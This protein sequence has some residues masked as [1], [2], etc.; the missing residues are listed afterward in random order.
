MGVDRAIV[1]SR[2]AS[3]FTSLVNFCW[4][5][6]K[7]TLLLTFVSILAGGGYLYFRLDDEIRRQVQLRFANHY[8]NFD[9]HIGSA[10]FDPDRGIAIDDLSLT[11]KTAD[12]TAAEPLLSIDEMYLVGNLRIE[13]LVTNQMQIDEV[14]VRHAHMRIERQSDG[15]WNTTALLPLPHFSEQSPKITIEDASATIAYSIAQGAK[16]IALQAV[17]VKLVPVATAAGPAIT[18]KVFHIEG[19]TNGLPARDV[20]I[21][22][23]LGTASGELDVAVTTLGLDITPELLANLPA[24][25]LAKMSGS[26]VSGQADVTLQLNRPDANTPVNWSADFKVVRGRLTQALLPEPLTDI[27]LTGR[28]DPQALIIE[29][30]DGKCGPASVVLAL[31]RAG[32]T[33]GAPLAMSAKVDGLLLTE[34]LEKTLPESYARVWKRFRPIG[35]VDA[36]VRLTFDGLTWK[37]VVTANCRGISLTDAEKFPY[38]VEQTTGQVVYRA[39][40]K[41]SADQLTLDLVGVGGGRPIKVEAQLT[42]LAPDDPDG[43]AM[44]E[45][46]ATDDITESKNVHAAGYRGVRYARGRAG[47]R[48]PLGFVEVS[49]TDVPLHEQLIVALPPKAQDLVRS[50]Q[51]QG[52]LDF[53][54]RAEWKDLSQ[55]SATVTQEIRLKNCRIQFK[56]FPFPLQHVQGVVTATDDRWTLNNIEACGANDATTVRCRGEVVTHDS[57]CEADLLFEAKNVPLDDN[58]RLA[59]TPAGQ[60][61]WSELKP[62]GNIDFGAHITQQPNE[63]EPNVDIAMKPRDKSVS[64]EPRMFPYRLAEVEGTAVY[65]RGKVD[66]K[67]FIAHHDRSVYSAEAG[68]WQVA[69]DGGWQCSVSKMN[70]DRLVANR[71]LIVALP[72]AVQAVVEKLQ[73]S[74]TIGLYDGSLSFAKSGQ[75]EGLTAAWDVKLECQQA[76][77]QGAVPIRGITG[78]IRLVGRGDGRTAFGAGQ[79]ALDSVLCKDIQL[80]NVRGPFWADAKRCLMGEPACLQQNQPPQRL[81]A[82]AYGGSVSTNIELVHDAPPSYKIDALIGGVNLARFASERPGSPSN[83]NGTMSG[84]LIVAGTGASTQTMRGSGE[85]H[86]VDANIYQVPALVAMLSVLKNRTPDTTAFNRCDME[87][88]VQGEH[89]HFDHLNLIGDAVSLYG[90]G[91]ANFNR[92]LDLEFYTLIGLADLPIWKTLAGHVSQQTLM[93]KVVGPFDDPKVERKAVPAVSD[94]LGQLQTDIQGGSTT[95]TPSTATR[96]P[97]PPGR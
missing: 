13:Q 15:G 76:S 97:R 33:A 49:G 20:R 52:S 85:L 31:N 27:A 9:V 1:G 21:D 69:A 3:I 83:L 32:W 10:R 84:K 18:S 42:H 37:P 23:Q 55:R 7:W 71:E 51:G 45:G 91:D 77:I 41:G 65:N 93:L 67:N 48:H 39:A 4:S 87:F 5:F 56:R 50:L 16:P 61:A 70:V 95:K 72:P 82:D 57:G 63:L 96:V 88:Q 35:M 29:R 81:T 22:G 34:Q 68:T 6:F 24:S 38:A 58:L 14:V 59:L 79:L 12:G 80:T 47:P 25:V 94:M 54:F 26:E 74:G 28:A 90:R 40:D 89:V 43:P 78:G 8:T 64:F 2:T 19:T 73:P 30:M 17:N 92:T 62:Q 75:A 60:Q 46:V 11:P 53:R 66:F 86:V 44:G 36:N